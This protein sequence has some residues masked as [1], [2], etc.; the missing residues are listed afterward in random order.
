MNLSNDEQE[1]LSIVRQ[2]PEIIARALTL[3]LDAR[4]KRVQDQKEA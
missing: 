3:I 2:H 4:S 1:L